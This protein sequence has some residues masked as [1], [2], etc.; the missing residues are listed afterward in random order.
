MI[1]CGFGHLV[2]ALAVLGS[3]GCAQKYASNVTD[4][5]G[6]VNLQGIQQPIK[7]ENLGTVD[8]PA[9]IVSH[10]ARP[11]WNPRC[12]EI[13]APPFTPEDVAHIEQAA[14]DVSKAELR[15]KLAD[16]DVEQQN[17]AAI[18]AGAY[19][20]A[21]RYYES[22]PEVI[23]LR[24]K[25][26]AYKDALSDYKKALAA[27]AAA[28][29]PKSPTAD[30]TTAQAFALFAECET[31]PEDQRLRRN[32]IQ[33]SVMVTAQRRCEVYKQTLGGL[34]T[35]QSFFFGS[36]ST[37]TG[38]L[39]GLITGAAPGL[40]AASGISSGLNAEFNSAVLKDSAVT[41]IFTGID[42]KRLEIANE[43][44][45]NRALAVKDYTLEE[46]IGDSIRYAG[47]CS[48]IE[49]LKHVKDLVS[50]PVGLE[51]AQ[52]VISGVL[53]QTALLRV[54]AKDPK[55]QPQAY[56]DL[57]AAWQDRGNA[58]ALAKSIA[59]PSARVL[60]SVGVSADGK[61]TVSAA[62]LAASRRDAD[63][64][65]EKIVATNLKI[66]A[67]DAQVAILKSQLAGADS[68]TQASLN[69]KITQLN[70][71]KANLEAQLTALKQLLV[72]QQSR[73][74]AV[75]DRVF[76]GQTCVVGWLQ[77][78]KF[79]NKDAEG[80]KALLGLQRLNPD[81]VAEAEPQMAALKTLRADLPTMSSDALD[82][83]CSVFKAQASCSCP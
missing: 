1:R 23:V 69:A 59:N 66:A 51:V 35:G 5:G 67:V 46:S 11:S 9:L 13:G 44:T 20:Y 15:V 80:T 54:R 52:Q 19:D 22:F 61:V 4:N 49:G 79:G 63:S 50:R 41:V 12:K 29:A 40:A 74:K 36:I 25:Q 43:I 71:Q 47:A 68:T 82:T 10:T 45:A 21:Y 81:L 34:E 58:E 75:A 37:I 73:S 28:V 7:E 14:K 8:L 16:H 55:E 70:G 32:R 39:G 83:A 42:A 78:G 24:Q 62:A 76:A 27:H 2:V 31:D 33:S 77:G 18:N 60:G 65:A 30:I 38:A 6:G 3:G 17:Y 56:Q 53:D 72:D 64:T 57:L 26:A 48:M